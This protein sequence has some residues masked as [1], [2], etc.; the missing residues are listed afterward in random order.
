MKKFY[1]FILGIALLNACSKVPVESVESSSSMSQE[2]S[3]EVQESSLVE[4]TSGRAQIS[5][6]SSSQEY[7]Y[8]VELN[9]LLVGEGEE[10]QLLFV[11]SGVNAPLAI[12]ISMDSSQ[13]YLNIYNRGENFNERVLR[14][15]Y[16]LDVANILT[17]EIT[18]FGGPGSSENKRVVKVNTQLKLNNYQEKQVTEQA[19]ESLDG[20]L[21]YL[22]YNDQGTVSLATRNFAGNVGEEDIETMMEYVQE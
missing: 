3:E 17:K 8:S 7:P 4:S 20:D 14:S 16:Q 11:S 18:L 15:I 6:M 12:G 19:F 22:F 1:L 5:E 2:S 10:N 13:V 9:D 21:M